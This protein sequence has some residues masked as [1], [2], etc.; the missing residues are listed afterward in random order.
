MRI[1]HLEDDLKDAEIVKEMLLLEGIP[2]DIIRVE[3]ERSF[4][5]ALAQN[6]FDLIFADYSLPSF[7]GIS[8][9]RIAK[10][11]APEIPFIFIT[12]KMGEDRAIETLRHGATDYIL[13]D[14]LSRLVP[15][16][17][18]ALQETRE[19]NERKRGQEVLEFS[20]LLLQIVNRHTTTGALL[21][22]FLEGI[23][24]FTDCTAVGIRLLDDEGRIPY[25]AFAGFSDE[26]YKLESPLSLQSD[27]CMCI[28]VVKGTTNPQ[29]PFYTQG[30]SFYMN[31]TTR[32]LA[33]VS[34]EDKGETRNACNRF[35]YESVALV[36]IR[37]EGN[38]IG[39]I[40]LADPRE[41]LVLLR[42]VEVLEDVALQLGMA[43]QHIKIEEQLKESEKKLRYLSS[44]LMTAQETERK[45]IAGE[46]HDSVVASL[47]AIRFSI[48]KILDKEEHD[49]STREDLQ[50]IIKTV[51][52]TAV[53]TRRVMAALRPSVLDDLG[54][55]PAINWFCREYEK[56]FSHIS[57]EK[58]IDINENALNENSSLRTP[59]FRICQEALNN[60]AKHSKA[61]LVNLRLYATSGQIELTIRD[62]GQ[63]FDTGTV[64]RGLGLSTMR[65]RT[66]LS[67][68][69]C[70]IESV[71]GVGTTVRCVWPLE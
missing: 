33:T 35:G 53:E 11:K 68:G 61:S 24:K 14:T 23:K 5:D 58:Q 44:E 64:T 13:K 12:G 45:R 54:I 43:I 59:L 57:V 8:A 63:G 48:E 42:K 20:H 38:V 36:P 16:V 22:E 50:N 71:K 15:A 56:I 27:R 9:L 10:E 60:V 30:G 21:E 18:R 49:Q 47:G 69:T 26:F 67:G 19:K 37:V 6:N 46:L 55:V 34:E 65:E 7:D 1:L 2:C 62:N 3:T 51:Q 25:E 70:S 29:L 66:E 41:N 28:N 40:H 32:F 39:V 31:G 52:Q 17:K 4:V